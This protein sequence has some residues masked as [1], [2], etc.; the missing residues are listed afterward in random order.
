MSGR[1][2]GRVAV[3]TGGSRGIGKA[4]AGAMAAEGATVVVASRKEGPLAATAAELDAAHPGRVVAHALH[5]GHLSDIAGWFDA[6]EADVGTP[7]I[8]VNNAGTNPYFGPMMG[9]DWAAW[10]KT[11][12]VNVKG[13]FEM[14]RQLVQR[15][16]LRTDGV[17]ASIIHMSSILGLSSSRM[18]G[19][20][21]MTKAALISMTR[22]LAAEL[23]PSGIRVNA[24]APGV[25]DTKLAAAIT[26]NDT[27]RDMVLSHTAL[28]RIAEPDEIAGL[29]VYLASDESS[30]MTGQTLPV[31]GG[32]LVC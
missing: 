5:V 6:V 27:M 4:I 13:P 18:Q 17:P 28:G 8:L 21:G 3:V 26:T 7:S 12:E 15:H 16:L 14:T 23:G 31:D 30:Y 32:Y 2:E 22:T 29:A 11:F 24:I 20:Y 9:V 10:D 1:L 25:V 19:V